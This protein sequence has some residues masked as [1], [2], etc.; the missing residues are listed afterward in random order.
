M[1]GVRRY[2]LN[3]PNGPDLSGHQLQLGNAEYVDHGLSRP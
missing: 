2:R 3:R 1:G